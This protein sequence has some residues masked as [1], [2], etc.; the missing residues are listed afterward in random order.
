MT[1]S[2]C[3]KKNIIILT[4]FLFLFLLLNSSCINNTFARGGR[5]EE[6]E[7]VVKSDS[8]RIIVF[9]FISKSYNQ[10]PSSTILE[11]NI[12]N[13]LITQ[14]VNISKHDQRLK[15]ISLFRQDL[16]I[17]EGERDLYINEPLRWMDRKKAE[18]GILA[19]YGLWG[20]YY[21]FNDKLF[22]YFF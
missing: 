7:L 10:Y 13:E 4:K 3:I 11:S 17:L 19:D 22:N 16:T 1:K 12:T 14:L 18:K 15:I 5:D 20:N 9:P 21:L 6:K 2:E 8:I